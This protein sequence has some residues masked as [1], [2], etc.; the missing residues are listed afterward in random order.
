MMLF[1]HHIET[2]LCVCL[3]VCICCK[4]YDANFK[5]EGRAGPRWHLEQRL[6]GTAEDQVHVANGF[7]AVKNRNSRSQ[8]AKNEDLRGCWSNENKW[9]E[10]EAAF[11]ENAKDN[12]EVA[13]KL[14]DRL[15]LCA[16]LKKI[17]KVFCKH[18]NDHWVPREVAAID[19]ERGE[20]ASR[21]QQV[22]TAVHFLV[23]HQLLQHMRDRLAAAF[24]NAR[25]EELSLICWNRDSFLNLPS[26]AE[27]AKDMLKTN[28]VSPML[29]ERIRAWSS[30]SD[31]VDQYAA[32]ILEH[33]TREFKGRIE[34]EFERDCDPSG[35]EIHGFVD[36]KT[37]KPLWSGPG[38]KKLFLDSSSSG[39]HSVVCRALASFMQELGTNLKAAFKDEMLRQKGAFL[40]GSMSAHQ[41]VQAIVLEH[42][43]L[44]CVEGPNKEKLPWLAR[45]AGSIQQEGAKLFKAQLEEFEGKIQK[46]DEVKQSLTHLLQC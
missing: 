31:S 41:M 1:V 33:F 23:S 37:F 36:L 15:G 30:I 20:L 10:K 16:L 11:R 22:N 35:F 9:F 17:D 32:R 4:T 25:L 21:L 2:Y 14:S 18:L 13:R 38:V 34:V 42:V 45:C 8:N 44:P 12:V 46:C 19:K 43:V 6:L 3:L 39:Q 26:L 7:V 5:D 24:T 28:A 27:G 40:A 29:I